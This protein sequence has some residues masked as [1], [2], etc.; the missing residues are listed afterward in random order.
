MKSLL[1]LQQ[2][3]AGLILLIGCTVCF[4]GGRNQ[5]AA[6]HQ[7]AVDTL[8]EIRELYGGLNEETLRIRT[9]LVNSYDRLVHLQDKISADIALFENVFARHPALQSPRSAA[10]ITTL[11]SQIAEEFRRLEDFKRNNSVVRNSLRYLPTSHGLAVQRTSREQHKL[12]LDHLLQDT[13]LYT[14]Q[15]DA[16]LHGK[17]E[18]TLAEVTAQSSKA[19][20]ERDINLFVLHTRNILNGETVISDILSSLAEHRSYET[21]DELASAYLLNY[22]S[23]LYKKQGYHTAM[24]VLFVMVLIYLGVIIG[25]LRNVFAALHRSNSDLQNALERAEAASAAKSAF[26]ANMSHEIRTPLNGIQGALH[27]LKKVAFSGHE[28]QFLDVAVKSCEGLGAIINDVLDL[29][30]IES[31][32][33]ELYEEFFDVRSLV[34]HTIDTQLPRANEKS[35]ALASFV[36]PAVP[37]MIR[38]DRTR[39]GQILLNLI[40]NAVKFTHK[41]WVVLEVGC[42]MLDERRCTLRFDVQDSGIG[43][44]EEKCAGLFE[45][46]TQADVSTTKKYGG[47]GL[48]LTICRELAHL[49]AGEIGVKSIEGEGSTFWLRI[50]ADRKAEDLESNRYFQI[51]PN[52]VRLLTVGIEENYRKVLHK[53]IAGWGFQADSVA[54]PAHIIAALESDDA[55][56]YPYT[57]AIV[58]SRLAGELRALLAD[59]TAQIPI[60]IAL[61]VEAGWHADAADALRFKDV[62]QIIRP[63]HQSSLFDCLISMLASFRGVTAAKPALSIGRA[64]TIN[65]YSHLKVLLAEDNE[66]NQLIAGELLKELGIIPTMVNNGRRA[67]EAFQQEQFDLVLLDCHMPEMDGLEAAR[68]IREHEMTGPTPTRR[69]PIVALTADVTLETQARCKEVGMDSYLSKPLDPAKLAETL[70]RHFPDSTAKREENIFAASPASGPGA[71]LQILDR[72]SLEARFGNNQ[73]LVE[74][75]LGHFRQ[76]LENDIPKFALII[77]EKNSRQLFELAHAL[78]GAAGAAGA[79]RLREAAL[80]L[81]T[82][83]RGE[84]FDGVDEVLQLLLQEAENCK[85]MLPRA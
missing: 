10:I 59:R 19:A 40:G 5:Y 36:S 3:L 77:S 32:K 55:K 83:G 79:M 70:K 47:T 2:W 8:R 24:Y 45:A 51:Q 48:G 57:A 21:I 25:R 41:G 33:M 18:K 61:L 62:Q 6:D 54:T 4:I 27:V 60:P 23:V 82:M 42:D 1:S 14:T 46:F 66:V 44:P 38:G 71:A 68:L 35:I 73:N 16:G 31:G 53:Q 81:E 84:Q 12:L 74:M 39:L 85:K 28:R 65:T 80:A 22:R 9:G 49:M 52:K 75:V 37:E 76:Q 29:S 50:S 26:L 72:A 17:V 15:P 56:V 58:N 20:A 30:K 34:E 11:R 64:Q 69:V 43:I 13:L 67:I 7:V 78:K 63:L